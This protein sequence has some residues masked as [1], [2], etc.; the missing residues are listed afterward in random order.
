LAAKTFIAFDFGTRKIGVAVGQTVT[1]T[2]TPLACLKVK[3]GAANWKQV[4][5]L[6]DRWQ[7]TGL[8]VGIPLHL[9]A[10]SQSMTFKARKF[11]GEL[12]NNFTLPVYEVDERLTTVEARARL[13][14]LGGFKALQKMSVDSF[15]A[16]LIL[17]TWMRDNFC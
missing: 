2:A 16:K 8:V 12:A 13:Y 15:A 1:M 4:S 10:T 6:L 17:E 11:A 7:P 14:E 5:I 9:D 3:Q